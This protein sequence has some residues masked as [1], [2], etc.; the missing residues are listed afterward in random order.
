LGIG[1]LAVAVAGLNL[2]LDLVDHR[3]LAR[4]LNLGPDLLRRPA[5]AVADRRCRIIGFLEA[6]F[7][8]QILL[9][10]KCLFRPEVDHLAGGGPAEVEFF[11]ER[12]A[13]AGF[14]LQ[15]CA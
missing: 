8:R 9:P 10:E 4:G 11:L 12:D 13:R 1:D 15:Q 2:R 6:H 7:D 3:A 5:K 14:R